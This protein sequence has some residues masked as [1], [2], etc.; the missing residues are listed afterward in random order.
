MYNLNVY[1]PSFF[2]FR[3]RCKLEWRIPIV[4]NAIIKAINPK[5]VLDLGCGRGDY[6]SGFIKEGI[7]A[8]GIEGS[9][10]CVP[11]LICSKDKVEIFD[12]RVPI[13][14]KRRYDLVMCL[15]VVE[16]IEDE[17][18]DILINNFKS[19]SD[20]V[21]ISAAPPGQGG[22]C[23]VN[24]QPKEYWIEKMESIGYI[25]DT[26]ICDRIKSLFTNLKRKEIKVYYNN[27][28]Y[29]IKNEKKN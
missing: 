13:S 22:V 23:H 11:E 3:R 9:K 15:E 27:L 20:K 10:Y 7:D 4:C 12:L 18:V 16:H 5:S 19:A 2:A 14:F 24:C 26:E 29:F 1:S 21:L 25:Q 6:V 28:L 8:Y 17:F